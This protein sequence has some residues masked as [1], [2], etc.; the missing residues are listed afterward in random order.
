M[1]LTDSKDLPARRPLFRLPARLQT[2]LAGEHAAAQ[3]MAGTAFAI[4]IASAAV[5]FLSQILLARWMGS[6][7][8]GTYVYAFTWLLL[9]GDVIHF[10]LPTTAQRFIPEYTQRGA[11]DLLRGFLLGSRWITFAM[12]TAVAVLGVV[13]VRSIETSLDRNVIMPLYLACVCLPF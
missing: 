5:V 11:L 8:F 12:G 4:R 6:S 1:A 9:I 13:I 2:W 3:R 7:E 10:G